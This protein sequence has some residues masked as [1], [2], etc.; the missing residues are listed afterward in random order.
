MGSWPAD[1]EKFQEEFDGEIFNTGSCC[2]WW[3]LVEGVQIPL[4][5][6]KLFWEMAFILNGKKFLSFLYTQYYSPPPNWK[7]VF[8][9]PTTDVQ[10]VGRP[11]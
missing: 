1:T 7:I 6:L 3:H 2:H 8:I 10:Y 4:S 5:P 11:T 9:V